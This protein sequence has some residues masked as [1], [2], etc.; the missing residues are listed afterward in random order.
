MNRATQSY[1]PWDVLDKTVSGTLSRW[2]YLACKSSKGQDP[3]CFQGERSRIVC[4]DGKLPS[5]QSV[6]QLCNNILVSYMVLRSC[7]DTFWCATLF[8]TCTAIFSA[9]G[10]RSWLP[11]IN[12]LRILYVTIKIGLN[13][14]EQGHASDWGARHTC[15][16]LWQCN[17]VAVQPSTAIFSVPRTV[18]EAGPGPGGSKDTR[19]ST[20][21]ATFIQTGC[22]CRPLYT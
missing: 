16:F 14:L 9:D 2:L 6:F 18:N 22:R 15:R 3:Q 10:T 19:L 7:T 5:F 21:H 12:K 20:D 1:I 4:D 13:V 17:V 11:T 8:T